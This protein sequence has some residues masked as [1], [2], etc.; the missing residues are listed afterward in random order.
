[1]RRSVGRDCHHEAEAAD[2]EKRL[3]RNREVEQE[4]QRFMEIYA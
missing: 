4:V 2:I 3:G 1:M